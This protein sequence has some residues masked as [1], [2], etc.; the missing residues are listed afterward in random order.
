MGVSTILTQTWEQGKRTPHATA[1]RLMDEIN[2]E[3]KRWARMVHQP[4]A[5]AA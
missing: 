4:K 3:P 2:R 5:R 1:R